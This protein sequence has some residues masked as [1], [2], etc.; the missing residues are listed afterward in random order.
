MNKERLIRIEVTAEELAVIRAKGK[1]AKAKL[2][3]LVLGDREFEEARAVAIRAR[4]LELAVKDEYSLRPTTDIA[5]QVRLA[6]V[7]KPSVSMV[8]RTLHDWNERGLDALVPKKAGRPK[9]PLNEVEIRSELWFLHDEFPDAGPTELARLLQE[10]YGRRL[11]LSRVHHY[12][13]K[14]GIR[15]RKP[16]RRSSR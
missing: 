5:A 1:E 9:D 10:R 11:S 3:S 15:F 16:R 4:I 2:D 13:R 14:D 6:F 8:R 12:L 7:D